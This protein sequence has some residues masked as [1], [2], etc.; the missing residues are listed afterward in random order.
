[1]S[2]SKGNDFGSAMILHAK[3]MLEEQNINLLDWISS[4]PRLTLKELAFEVG[5]GVTLYGLWRFA[6][7]DASR[8]GVVRGIS[9]ILLFGLILDEFPEGWNNDCGVHPSV[10]LSSWLFAFDCLGQ[11]K[12]ADMAK[13]V[14]HDICRIN[15]PVDG[16]KPEDYDDATLGRAFD[17]EWVV[18]GE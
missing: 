4:N 5:N 12:I 14:Y 13:R 6:L 9:K 16:W 8:L 1:M 7:L 2:S 11:S 3:K 18:D 17:Q 15:P 10:K